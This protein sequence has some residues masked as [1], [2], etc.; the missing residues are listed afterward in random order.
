MQKILSRIDIARL[1]EQQ[2]RRDGIAEQD[3][4]ALKSN[5]FCMEFK[6]TFGN[7]HHVM[8]YAGNGHNGAIALRV[9]TTL[10]SLK[11]P[12]QVVLLNPTKQLPTLVR[13]EADNFEKIAPEALLEVTGNF[14]PPAI[15]SEDIL[16]DGICGIELEAPLSG[17][18]PNVIRYL[19]SVHCTKV[20]IDMPSGLL[21]GDNREV[22]AEHIF[23]A[24]Y[25][26]TF[27]APKLS[28]LFKEYADMIGIWK[29]LNSAV[30]VDS[31]QHTGDYDLFDLID[32]EQALLPRP[33]FSNK[34][35]YGRLLLIAGSRGMMGAALLAGRAAMVMGAGHL[36]LHLPH[37]AGMMAH[38]ALPEVLVS[39]DPSEDAFSSDQIEYNKYDCIAVGCGLG[40][41]VESALALEA[42]L[43]SYRKPI[44][45]DADALNI[46]AKDTTHRLLGMVPMGSVLTPHAGEFDRL[47]GASDNS[48]DRLQKAC[49]MAKQ[50]KVTI[51]LKGPY[52]ATCLSSGQV[53]FNSTGNPGLATAGTGD[54]LAGMVLALMGLGHTPERSAMI[55][56]YLH[57][58]AA[59]LYANSFCEESL[60]ASELIQQLPIALKRFKNSREEELGLY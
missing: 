47:F 59:D 24:H 22:P 28:F 49:E 2:M 30:D 50:Y 44:L 26:Y 55:A 18:L 32:M 48:F 51:L 11:Y 38:I 33:R 37:G 57:G 45:L 31:F 53:V 42:L 13:A 60:T 40:S 21:D 27:Y 25:T 46:L 4:I 23:H 41:Q 16:I 17:T 8:I 58:F 20:A 35:D 1:E 43:S 12:V 34:Y 10:H 56:A 52:T 5:A 36:T 39:E 7:H 29:V 6:R 3:L 54:V 9:A 15:A 14:A 19:N